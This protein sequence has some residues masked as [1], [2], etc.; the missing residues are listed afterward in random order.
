MGG[1]LTGDLTY[2]IPTRNRPQFLRRLLTFW[3]Y[4][5]PRGGLLIADCS[6]SWQH[7]KN[8]RVIEFFSDRLPIECES[9]AQSMIA[10]CDTAIRKVRTPYAVF[11][12]DDDFLLPDAVMECLEF[13]QKNSGYACAQGLLV[14]V[15]SFRDNRID[16]IRGYDLAAESGMSR[17]R[18]MAKYWYSTFYAVYPTHV[19]QENFRIATLCADYH[20]ARIFSEMMLTQMT[21][22][23]GKIK[24]FP[25]LFNVRQEHEQNDSRAL[26]RVQDIARGEQYYS[27]FRELLVHQIT[28]YTDMLADNA[29]AVVD[30]YYES[31]K[32][33]QMVGSGMAKVQREIAR[34][35]RKTLGTFWTNSVL[36]R[37]RL[38]ADHRLL[39]NSAWKLSQRL[40][41]EY[42]KGMSEKECR[43][44]RQQSDNRMSRAA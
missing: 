5:P 30:R 26:P 31:L 35:V 3:S 44:E 12:A 17:F 13:L 28:Q 23:Q 9:I 25:K 1:W 18:Q 34:S 21:T 15:N 32:H 7:Q 19:L 11:C 36:E 2:V 20:D 22:L 6:E 42:P 24:F 41:Q 37:R 8:R 40:I 39:D 4:F 16:L 43:L 27:A 10:K 14:S 29:T 33:G 38:S